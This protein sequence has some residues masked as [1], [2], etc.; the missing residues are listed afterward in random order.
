MLVAS[1]SA[2]LSLIEEDAEDGEVWTTVRRVEDLALLTDEEGRLG[3]IEVGHSGGDHEAMDVLPPERRP[4]RVPGAIF[5]VELDDH[6]FLTMGSSGS[7]AVPVLSDRILTP[8]IGGR[9]VGRIAA[10]R[11]MIAG[12][13]WPVMAEALKDQAWLVEESRGRGRVVIFAEDPSFR[14]TWEGLH[15]LLLNAVLIGPSLS[16]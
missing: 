8:S 16:R 14:G 7:V 5:R 2:S 10:E 4:L 12:Y 3:E 15:G 6:H 9:T 11:A 1:G 13:T